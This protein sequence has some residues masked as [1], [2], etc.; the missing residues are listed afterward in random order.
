MSEAWKQWE[1]QIV[2]GRFPL[3]QYLGGSDHGA[4]F[5]TER[6]ERDFVRAA[7]KLIPADPASAEIQLSRWKHAA[8]LFHPHLLRLFEMGHCE[9]DNVA[10]LYLVMEYAAENLSQILPQRPLSP[11]ETRDVFVPVLDA[12]ACVHRQGFVLGHLKPANVMAVGDKIKLSTDGLLR[13]SETLRVLK[14]GVY[15]PPESSSGRLSPASDVWSFGMTLVEALTQR[16]PVW[17]RLGHG[18]PILP[19]SLPSPYFDIARNCLRRDP[20]QRC[21]IADLSARLRPASAVPLAPAPAAPAPQ[22]YAVAPR[23]ATK[24]PKKTPPRRSVSL[25]NFT[26]P[27][28]TLPKFSLP[29]FSLPKFSLPKFSLP[30]LSLPKFSLPKFT[31]PKFTLPKFVVPNFALPLLAAVL[32]IAGIITVPKLLSRRPEPQK[33]SSL[34]SENSTPPSQ[35]QPKHGKAPAS[36]QLAPSMPRSTQQSAQ[37]PLKIASEKQPIKEEDVAVAPEPPALIPQGEEQPKASAAEVV[38]GEVLNEI[39]PD[40]SPKARDTIRGKV[41][42]SVKVHVDPS[43]D[44]AGAELASPGPSRYFADLALQAARRWEFAPAKVAGSSVS[45]DWMVRFEFSPLD[46]KVFPVQTSPR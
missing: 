19:K 15:D 25:P 7:I 1:G 13:A 20:Q 39:L 46:T 21:T 42:V 23:S 30:N 28:F 17:D 26:L 36:R 44:L 5:L 29:K 22:S 3:R 33:T 14:P 8:Q 9:L 38:P 27:K 34:V 31:P 41:R 6:G 11:E 10:L 4:V 24:P 37:K 16:A 2:D 32:V 12:L 40:V 35:V 43:G 18:D 45:T